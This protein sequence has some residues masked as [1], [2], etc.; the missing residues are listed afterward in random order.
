MTRAVVVTA[1]ELDQGRLQACGVPEADDAAVV[2]R[3]GLRGS[4]LTFA[5]GGVSLNGCDAIPDPFQ[6]P[7]RPFG[8]IW[9]GVAVGFFRDGKLNDPRLDLCTAEDGDLT[10]FV[11]VEP[12]P[13]AKWVVVSDAGTREVYE[14]A[15]SLPVRVTTTDGTQPESS[16]ASFPIEEYAADGTKL[17]EYV[18]EAQ[19]AG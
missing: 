13:D 6:E 3:V 1:S 2:E 15:G 14:V 4:S 18:L 17:R 11:W 10:G 8:G 5:G 7:D 16:K 19:V 9:C 12:Q